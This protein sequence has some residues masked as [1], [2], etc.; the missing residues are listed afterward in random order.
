[1]E[2]ALVPDPIRERPRDSTGVTRAEKLSG[3]LNVAYDAVSG[4]KEFQYSSFILSLSNSYQ[5]FLARK[6]RQSESWKM[7]GLL[8]LTEKKWNNYNKKPVDGAHCWGNW[9]LFRLFVAFILVRIVVFSNIVNATAFGRH[10]GDFEK[11]VGPEDVEEQETRE[12]DHENT[13]NDRALKEVLPA[14]AVLKLVRL[15][16]DSIHTGYGRVQSTHLYKSRSI[17]PD[18]LNDPERVVEE[19]SGNPDEHKEDIE[20]R[21]GIMPFGISDHFH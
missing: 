3:K 20:S 21:H 4:T 7:F 8:W 5:Q 12:H 14:V 6:R 18:A 11:D 1:M 10:V 19:S 16:I 13:G 15:V 2:H 9:T 17:E